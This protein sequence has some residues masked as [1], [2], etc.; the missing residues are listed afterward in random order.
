[1]DL[2]FPLSKPGSGSLPF[3]LTLSKDFWRESLHAPI[4]VTKIL[5][6]GYVLPFS[7][8]PNIPLCGANSPSVLRHFDLVLV[9][10]EALVDCGA[11]VE[12]LSPPAL[13]CPMLVEENSGKF[14][15][16]WDGRELNKHLS[17]PKF[18]YE[19]LSQVPLLVSEDDFLFQ[20]DLESAYH[21]VRVD[22]ACWSFLGFHLTDPKGR[23]R[24]FAFTVLPFGLA[25]ACLVFTKIMQV[26]LKHW[27]LQGFRGILY[28]DDGLGAAASE[29]DCLWWIA[30]VSQ[31]LASAG[32]TLNVAKSKMFPSRRIESFLGAEIDSSSGT[33]S[34]S[35]KRCLKLSG[36]CRSILKAGFSSARDLARVQGMLMSA[37]SLIGPLAALRSR[38]ISSFFAE[39]NVFG[40]Q[41][42]DETKSLDAS[43]ASDLR[44]WVD[45]CSRV[46]PASVAIWPK[47]AALAGVGPSAPLLQTDASDVASGSIVGQA[48][49]CPGMAWPQILSLRKSQQSL[50]HFVN[51]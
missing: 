41:A 33:W 38:S 1:M 18:K 29:A 32:L 24:W 22:E 51:C 37:E 8:L 48:R 12:L 19:G 35:A 49:P 26:L 14:R 40:S 4:W 2:R 23:K 9:K 42:W 30:R 34:W 45:F 6:S 10:V 27:R 13:C 39:V 50:P 44:F 43:V 31:D 47:P 25:P 11:A 16:C 46:P 17:F 36:L 15:L 20:F 7:S 28:L 3:R 21:H 5:D